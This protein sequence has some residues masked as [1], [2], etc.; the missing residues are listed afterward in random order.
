MIASLQNVFYQDGTENESMQVVKLR[1]VI[2]MCN[3]DLLAVPTHHCT[4]Q[5]NGKLC[6]ANIKQTKEKTENAVVD[7]LY[8]NKMK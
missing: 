8:G 2:S 6:C 4:R 7:A 5:P 1:K 3:G